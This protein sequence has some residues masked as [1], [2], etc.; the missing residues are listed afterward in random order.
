MKKLRIWKMIPQPIRPFWVRVRYRI[1]RAIRNFP[2]WVAGKLPKLPELF[3]W[4]CNHRWAEGVV[5]EKLVKTCALCNKRVVL[6]K[7][8]LHRMED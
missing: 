3:I 6:E 8:Y 4:K 5:D 7:D 2:E 1:R